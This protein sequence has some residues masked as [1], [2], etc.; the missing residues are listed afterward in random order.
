MGDIPIRYIFNKL[1]S[2]IQYAFELKYCWNHPKN[3]NILNFIENKYCERK[4]KRIFLK[5]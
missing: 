2:I 1:L 4:V 3:F 5:S